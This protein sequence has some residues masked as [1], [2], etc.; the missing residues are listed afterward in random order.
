MGFG[1]ARRVGGVGCQVGRVVLGGDPRGRCGGVEEGEGGGVGD[2]PP[3]FLPEPDPCTLSPG[4]SQVATESQDRPA[5]ARGHTLGGIHAP[6]SPG[7]G[8]TAPQLPGAEG[9]RHKSRNSVCVVGTW[10][11]GVGPAWV[12]LPDLPLTARCPE[13]LL[14]FSVSLSETW[15]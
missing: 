9:Q 1:Q 10:G 12:Q 14:D 6:S 13:V 3:G 2:Q 8:G 4:S 11:R 15:K 7:R 5:A